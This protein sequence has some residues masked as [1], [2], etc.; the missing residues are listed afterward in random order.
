MVS[1]KHIT[2]GPGELIMRENEDFSTQNT[3]NRKIKIVLT[4]FII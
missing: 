1:T 3:G 4:P 2:Y